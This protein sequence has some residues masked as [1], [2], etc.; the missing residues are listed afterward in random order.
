MFP[1]RMTYLEIMYD[2]GEDDLPQIGITPYPF[3]IW[4]RKMRQFCKFITEYKK[5]N[6]E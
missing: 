2:A 1:D 5:L 4:S 3:K 6:R